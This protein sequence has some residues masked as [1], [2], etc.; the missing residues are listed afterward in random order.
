[1]RKKW[2]VR[3]TFP[4]PKIAEAY[5]S[6]QVNPLTER[7][8]FEIPKLFKIKKYLSQVLGWTEEEVFLPPSS[9][10][11]HHFPLY[12]R[13]LPTRSLLSFSDPLLIEKHHH[14]SGYP[15]LSRIDCCCRAESTVFS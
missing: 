15:L 10:A 3:E 8:S 1:M 4:D 6:P 14:R 13:R 5:F 7:F 12:H 11:Y 9:L 2:C